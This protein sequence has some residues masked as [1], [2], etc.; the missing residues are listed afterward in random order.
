[1]SSTSIGQTRSVLHAHRRR[2]AASPPRKSADRHSDESK[3][4]NNRPQT[5]GGSRGITIGRTT[6]RLKCVFQFS[7]DPRDTIQSADTPQS[8]LLS[9]MLQFDILTAE[10]L[11][12]VDRGPTTDLPTYL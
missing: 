9:R 3:A 8:P 2:G 5:G 7:I 12:V 4:G 6:A 11:R 10:K 1:M